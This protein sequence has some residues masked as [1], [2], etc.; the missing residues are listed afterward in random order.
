MTRH[1][2]ALRE[3]ER[4]REKE[5]DT[6]CKAAPPLTAFGDMCCYVPSS[7]S[8]TQLNRCLVKT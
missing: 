5:R 3:R 8:D 1:T 7:V 2:M 4:E 6:S